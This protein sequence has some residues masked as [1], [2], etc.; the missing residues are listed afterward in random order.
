V[1]HVTAEDVRH[2]ARLLVRI[3]A[4]IARLQGAA[5]AR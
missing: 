4:A 2:P 1:L 3:R 5:E